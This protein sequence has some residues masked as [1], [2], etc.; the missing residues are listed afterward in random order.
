MIAGLLNE[1]LREIAAKYPL[2]GDIPILG[3]MFR[4][5]QFQKEETELVIIVTP[6]LVRPI[7]TDDIPLPTDPFTKARPSAIAP[8]KSAAAQIV[9]VPSGAS[10]TI[11]QTSAAGYILD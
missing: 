2:L 6:Y 7:S 4:S 3:A 9:P 1:Q 5:T 11:G 8:R 10:S